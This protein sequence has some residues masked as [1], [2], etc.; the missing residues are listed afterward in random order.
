MQYDGKAS[1]ARHLEV[2]AAADGAAQLGAR[3]A[4]D[5]GVPLSHR[6]VVG[7]HRLAVDG[8]HRRLL[9]EALQNLRSF[10]SSCG[11]AGRCRGRRPAAGSRSA[12]VR[13]HRA[14]AQ[15][16]RVLRRQL[17]RVVVAV[18]VVVAALARA[19]ERLVELVGARLERLGAER[20]RVLHLLDLASRARGLDRD[21]R[22]RRRRRRRL[23]R[24]RGGGRGAV[25][26]VGV[27]ARRV[28]AVRALASR[29]AS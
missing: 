26:A 2:P 7:E 4:E 10:R 20:R 25:D 15:L 23:V 13:V 5:G 22:R 19:L 6:L 16:H 24:I 29:Y 12:P 18:A 27:A 3:L 21:R 9:A 1:R 11:S 8:L 28:A 17:A 14:V